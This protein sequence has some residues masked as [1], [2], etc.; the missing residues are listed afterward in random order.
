MSGRLDDRPRPAIG[1][2]GLEDPGADE[3]PLRAELHHEGGVGRRRDPARAEQRDREPACLSDL[4]EHLERRPQLL[5][6]GCTLLAAESP[7]PLDPADDPAQMTNRLHD[8]PG[9]RLALGANHRRALADPPQGLAEV[10]RSA[11]ERDLEGVLVDVMRLVSRRQDLGLVDV[12]HL[13]RLQDLRFREVADS[14]LRHHRDRHDL[15]DLLDHPRARHPGDA[16]RRA[17]VG[18]HALERHHRHRARVLGDSRLIRGGHIHDHPALEHLGQAA[19]DP[20][21]RSLSHP[22]FNIERA[23]ASDAVAAGTHQLAARP[24]GGPATP[25]PKA[26]MSPELFLLQLEGADSVP[27]RGLVARVDPVRQRLDDAEQGRVGA[28]E[29]GAVG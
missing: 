28:R 29:R 3:V 6:L 9:A 25:E 4:L 12:V 22:T 13:E 7:E 15:L 8:V 21:R 19:L 2:L 26:R 27:E 11:D 1:V 16:A 17:D 10:G 24:V 23:R 5:R 18:R 20:E 14:G